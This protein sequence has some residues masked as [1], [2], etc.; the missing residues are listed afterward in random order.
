VSLQPTHG[1]MAPTARHAGP[2]R[3]GARRWAGPIWP[4]L[5][6]VLA[7]TVEVRFLAHST[8]RPVVLYDGDSLT[9]AVLWKALLQGE[10]MH[11]VMSSQLLLFPEGAIYAVCR[12][13]TTSISAALVAVAYLNIVS[14]YLGLRAVAAVVVDGSPDRRRVVAVIPTL[15]VIGA[16]LLE[17]VMGVDQTTIATPLLFDSFY[18]GVILVGVPALAFAA[19]QLRW[20]AERSLRWRMATTVAVSG[21]V[22]VTIISDPLFLIQFTAPFLLVAVVFWVLGIL[23]RTRLLWLAAPQVAGAGLYEVLAPLYGRYLGS[24][25]GTYVHPRQVHTAVHVL[26]RDLRLIVGGAAGRAELALVAA[27]W[28]GGLAATTVLLARARRARRRVGRGAPAAAVTAPALV[29][30]FAVVA[31]I[32]IVPL[33]IL[34]GEG[35]PRYLLPVVT[36]PFVALVPAADVGRAA[37]GGGSRRLGGAARA[38]PAVALAGLGVLGLSAIPGAAGILRPQSTAPS[39]RYGTPLNEGCLERAFDRR[40]VSGVAAYWTARAL[41][42][43]NTDGERVLQVKLDE[44]IFPWL[45][46]LGSYEHRRFSFVLVD[47]YDHAE[48]TIRPSDVAALGRPARI[49]ACPS[50]D[51]YTYPPGTAGYRRLN[52]R[53][54]G[55]LRADLRRYS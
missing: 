13:C 3:A 33:I 25:S 48:W 27:A 30:A 16:M 17:R 19:W 15:L 6:V 1:P 31:S 7:L 28:V 39:A 20:S 45:V 14:L 34:V 9:F 24:T 54:D 44:S 22:G 26:E 52:A 43:Y 18:A 36:F 35:V 55:S 5:V 50:F 29:A 47:R 53:I 11:P 4:I 32:S 42:L 21:V 38:L 40:P 10:P 23:P 37:W 46:D 2:G 12:L 51:I 8:W 49:V 41:D